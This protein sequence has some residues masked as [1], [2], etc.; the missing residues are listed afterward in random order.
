MDEQDLASL[1]SMPLPHTRAELLAR[2]PPARTALDGVIAALTEDELADLRDGAGWSAADHLSH[3]AAWERMIVAHLSDGSDHQIPGMDEASYAAATLDELNDRLFRLHRERP[4][5]EVLGEFR[6]AHAS[7]VEFIEGMA[8]ARLSEAY[9][10]D[11]PAKRTVRE[12]ISGDTYLHYR[13]HAD[14]IRELLA[15]GAT[16]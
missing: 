5:A 7:I 9:W 15:E 8:E 2:I 16:R 14:W 12:K 3:I 1:E 11:D 4:L 13:E 6:A 10:D